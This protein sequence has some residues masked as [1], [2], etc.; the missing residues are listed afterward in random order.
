MTKCNLQLEGKRLKQCFYNFI[1]AKTLHPVHFVKQNVICFTK[2][3]AKHETNVL[4][5][6][7]FTA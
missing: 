3:T 5:K 4:Q 6:D 2:C 1:D 7:I